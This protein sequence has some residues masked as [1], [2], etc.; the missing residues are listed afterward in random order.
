MSDGKIR[1]GGAKSKGR[2]A[3]LL[4]RI[5]PD[6]LAMLD[7]VA[8]LGGKKRARSDVI[9]DCIMEGVKRRMDD[10]NASTATPDKKSP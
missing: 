6:L 7:A 9:R 10:W 1:K 5:E 3:T 2:T 4:I 8:S